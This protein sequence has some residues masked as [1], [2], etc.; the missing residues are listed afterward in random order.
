MA[1]SHFLHV[2]VG[3]DRAKGG[4]AT[5]I[6]KVLATDALVL[7]DEVVPGRVLRSSL[8]W[9]GDAQLIIWNFHWFDIG[10]QQFRVIKKMLEEDLRRPVA[11]PCKVFVTIC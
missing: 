11:D 5:V 6:D 9:G 3:A 8:S 4:V 2:S 10:L 7:A 1:S